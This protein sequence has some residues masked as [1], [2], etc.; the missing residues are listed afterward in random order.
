MAVDIRRSIRL[1]K[2]EYIAEPEPKSGI[3]LHHTVCDDAQTT[4]RL[5][6]NDRD[7]DGTTRRVATAYVIDFGGAI[8]EVFDP[9]HWA[10]HLGPRWP[11]R[12]R[13]AF[14][15]RFIGIEISSPGGLTEHEG[16][17]YKYGIIDPKFVK[18]R[19]DA[20]SCPTPYRG[21]RWFARYDAEQIEA[22]AHLV[23]H[24]CEQ[25]AIPR[26]YP[27]KPYL[28]YGEALQS[29]EGVI[30]HA[31]VRPD[32]SDPAPDPELWDALELIA[33]LEPVAV[34][35]S[36]PTFGKHL[37]PDEI[38]ALFHR[39]VRRLDRMDVAAGS[40]V[41]ALMMELDRRRT[42]VELNTPDPGAHDIGYDL[43]HGDAQDVSRVAKALGFERVTDTE[44]EVPHA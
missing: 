43:V 15:K 4:I 7:D 34:P 29:F 9:T 19:D 40:L 16:Q 6:K 24:L 33:G 30:G 13:V 27:D 3:A 26:V 14:E 35:G 18:A 41:K 22:L 28:Y 17:L 8:Y 5:W 10:F 1:P 31:M 32:K 12:Q 23:D 38:E 37:T 36:A 42:Y 11:Y 21:F 25:F 2:D 39:N 44:L 20:L